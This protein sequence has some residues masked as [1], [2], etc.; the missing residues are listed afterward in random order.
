MLHGCV[1]L[2]IHWIINVE[3]IPTIVNNY[4]N[5]NMKISRIATMGNII[6]I[7]ISPRRIYGKHVYIETIE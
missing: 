1:N 5:Y 4:N 2:G 7:K 6:I 3:I